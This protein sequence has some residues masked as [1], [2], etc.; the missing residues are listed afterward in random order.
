MIPEPSD[1]LAWIEGEADVAELMPEG[2]SPNRQLLLLGLQSYASEVVRQA[3]RLGAIPPTEQESTRALAWLDHP[4]FV[5][6]H[7]RTGTTLL[8]NLL[9][10]HPDVVVLPS[11]GT[12]LTSFAYAN[13][14]LMLPTVLRFR[15]PPPA[16]LSRR[17]R[18][19]WSLHHAE[20]HLSKVGCRIWW[21]L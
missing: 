3:R 7:H 15:W 16:H 13:P 17:E 21:T 18:R 5:C 11:E 6:G 1:S 4:V 19:A 2:P 12:Y 9:D 20:K 10:G 8:R 14:G